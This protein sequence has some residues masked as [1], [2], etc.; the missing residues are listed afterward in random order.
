[1]NPK[2]YQAYKEQSVNT[3]TKGEM[4]LLLYDEILK[5]LARAE[6]SLEKKD[7]TMFDQSVGRCREIVFYLIETLNYDYP[8]SNEL[9]RMY[10]FFIYELSRLAAGRNPEII[11]QLH[12]LVKELR[13]AYAQAS[14]SSHM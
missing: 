5:R 3:M 2:G 13:D 12:G 9:K 14:S 1:M 7:Y 6:F 8:I 11:H 4:L 10:D